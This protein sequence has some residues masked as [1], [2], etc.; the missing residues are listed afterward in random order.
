MVCVF[1]GRGRTPQRWHKI[2]HQA[3]PDVCGQDHLCE[4]SGAQWRGAFH[5]WLHLHSGAGEDHRGQKIQ[6]NRNRWQNVCW[7]T[8]SRWWITWRSTLASNLE[9]WMQRFPQSI[10]PRWSRHTWS[11]D[12]SSTREFASL[13]TVCRRTFGSSIYWYDL[14]FF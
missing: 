11:C 12:S 3:E 10:W 5:R 6:I 1:A 8:V 7:K 9:T 13:V 4:G 14:F 2:N